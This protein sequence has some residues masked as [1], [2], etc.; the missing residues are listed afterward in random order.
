[1]K[2]TNRVIKGRAAWPKISRVAII[3]TTLYELIETLSDVVGSGDE[4]LVNVVVLA[5]IDSGRMRTSRSPDSSDHTQRTITST[6]GKIDD[7]VRGK[8]MRHV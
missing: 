6:P 4:K 7:D 1:V 5:L 3:K 8:G 2:V